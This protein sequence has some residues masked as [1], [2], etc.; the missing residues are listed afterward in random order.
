MRK[1]HK[2]TFNRNEAFALFINCMGAFNK[3]GAFIGEGAFINIRN[4]MGAF[5]REGR[6]IE[7]GRLLERI[8]YMYRRN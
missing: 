7:S 6:L 2:D 4:C 1:R 5:N 3:E 8:R